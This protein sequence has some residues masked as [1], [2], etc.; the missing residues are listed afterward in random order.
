M[1]DLSAT[2]TALLL[3][4]SVIYGCGRY[5]HVAILA[6]V[7]GAVTCSVGTQ[8]GVKF[9]VDTLSHGASADVWDGIS[10]A[11]VADRRR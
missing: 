5:S 9:L 7:L 4:C 11:R 8:Y 6:A 1:D 2:Q 10:S 3:S